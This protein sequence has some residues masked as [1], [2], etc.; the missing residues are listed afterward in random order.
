VPRHL[1]KNLKKKKKKKRKEKDSW[2]AEPPHKRVAGHPILLGGGL[3]TPRQPAC[4]WVHLWVAEPPPGPKG[5]A[6][7]HPKKK[8]K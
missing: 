1:K 8:N 4:G 3:A 2:V 7:P 6:E 5:V